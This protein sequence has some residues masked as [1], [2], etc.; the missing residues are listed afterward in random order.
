M[1]HN[2]Q[3]GWDP[4]A[5]VGLTATEAAAA[6][7]VAGRRNEPLVSDPFAEPLVHAVGVEFLTRL[8][9]QSGMDDESGFAIP[10]MV[11]WVAA[12][13]RFF[14]DYFI[15]GQAAGVRQAVILGAGLDSRA[16]RL[17][18]LSGV[19]V[20]EVD[21]QG[22]VEFKNRAMLRL[23]VEPRVDR[24]T[25]GVDLRGDWTSPLRRRGLDPTRPTM[26]CAEGLL[27]Y[28]PATVQMRILDEVAALSS[29]GSRFAADVVEDVGQ[30]A[31]RVAT[32]RGE[33]NPVSASRVDSAATGPMRPS[34]A[35][36]QRLRSHGW[37]SLKQTAAE[38][39]AMYAL[40]PLD[41]GESLYRQI[42]VVTAASA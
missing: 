24:R 38:L 29:R 22:V 1:V 33:N 42:T 12:R 39:F 30:I 36:A 16:Y 19:T 32:V 13:S 23:R 37:S 41:E 20:Y 2:D 6:R 28:L 9:Q 21:R 26:W 25:V 3:E 5:G 4:A 27:P 8:A 18:W 14:D 17:P 7:A 35:A 11:D 10:R 31:A 40:A 15:T 34:S